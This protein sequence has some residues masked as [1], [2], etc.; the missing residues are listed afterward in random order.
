MQL[1]Y[2]VYEVCLKTLN[3]LERPPRVYNRL[4]ELSRFGRAEESA[5]LVPK[6]R[7]IG[8]FHEPNH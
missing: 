6:V 7:G 8:H 1:I 2:G 5:L 4:N 3:P